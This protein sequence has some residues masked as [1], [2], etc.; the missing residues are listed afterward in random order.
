ML[1]VKSVTASGIRSGSNIDIT[2]IEEIASRDQQPAARG[3]TERYLSRS[4]HTVHQLG[5]Y[6][7]KRNYLESVIEDTLSWAQRCGLVDDRRYAAIFVRSH[8]RVSPMGNFRIRM[9]LKKRGISEKISHEVLS[10]REEE[11][12]H[13]TLL[14]T[15]KNRYGHLEREAG[16]RRAA[17][18][19]QRRGFQHDLIRSLLDEVFPK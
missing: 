14:K 6:L 4:E 1:S 16:M 3:D 11:E 9:E 19:L 12:M 5:V 8:S 2:D 7:S 10:I 13:I 15:V 18:Y 17:G